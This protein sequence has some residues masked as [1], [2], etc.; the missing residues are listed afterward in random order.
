M[1]AKLDST[2]IECEENAA[3]YHDFV[4]SFVVFGGAWPVTTKESPDPESF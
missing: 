3:D 2:G 1:V 4:S